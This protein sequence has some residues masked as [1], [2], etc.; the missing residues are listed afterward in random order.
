MECFQSIS[1][2]LMKWYTIIEVLWAY[3]RFKFGCEITH[4]FPMMKKR[5]FECLLDVVM[6]CNRS[7][8]NIYQKLLHPETVRI[9][10]SLKE[11]T[12]WNYTTSTSNIAEGGRS[13]DWPF[14]HFLEVAKPW[15][16][17]LWMFFSG[18]SYALK[19]VIL[20]VC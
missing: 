9:E 1:Y 3:M 12:T 8:L 13:C 16:W 19:L 14:E 7:F 4:I 5:H 17:K 15:D 11:A 2:I 18:S 10:C 6:P 20:N